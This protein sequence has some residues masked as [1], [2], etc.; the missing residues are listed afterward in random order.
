MGNYGN[1]NRNILGRHGGFTA[2]EW[3]TYREN[4]LSGKSD[5]VAPGK[6]LRPER[7]KMP[8]GDYSIDDT[9]ATLL[10]SLDKPFVNKPLIH[11]KLGCA[12]KAKGDWAQAKKH[13]EIAARVGI[14]DAK[15]ELESISGTM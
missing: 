11:Y 4:Q 2:D 13:L 6:T 1:H 5:Y 8:L 15:E 7:Y 14:S 3:D 9:I 10:N 12:Y